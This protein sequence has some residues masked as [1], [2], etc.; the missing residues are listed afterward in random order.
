MSGPFQLPALPW[1]ENALAPT[2]SAKTISL[3]HG[4]HHLAYVKKLNELVAGT[5]YADQ[6]LEQIIA[7]TV[8]NPETQKIFNN[9]AQTWNHTFYWNCLRPGAGGE[10]RGRIAKELEPFGGYEGFKKKLAQAAVETFGS[11]WAWL[12]AR[13]GKLEIISTSNAHNPLTMGATPLL[14]I[15][16]WE[17]AYYVDYENRRPEHVDAVIDRLLNWKWAE[18][19]L[20]KSGTAQRKAA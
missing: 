6:S 19:Q 18:E 20:E 16:V 13:D 7:G 14:T 1:E 5:P 17:H 11:G 8:G 3:H 9:A 12:V 4:K 15:D 2:I 10:P